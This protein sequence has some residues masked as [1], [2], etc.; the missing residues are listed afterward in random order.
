[1]T[2]AVTIHPATEA[3]YEEIVDILIESYSEYRDTFQPQEQWENYLKD[4]RESPTNPYIKQ[5]WIAK[6]D[7]QIVGTVQLFE[8]AHK[9]YPT[10]ELPIDY[11]F[12]RLLG[13]DP[14][15]RG[16]GIARKLLQQCVESAKDMGK[17]TVYLYTGGQMVNAIRL[18]E[19]FGFVEDP[20]FSSESGEG[21]A[22]CYRYDS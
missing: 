18:Y 10:F 5:L 21:K 9:A 12:I 17:N 22:I 16:H 8:T 14:K 11:P 13:V 3:D 2:T 7:N 1:M 20:E 6:I 15:W 4:I 19:R